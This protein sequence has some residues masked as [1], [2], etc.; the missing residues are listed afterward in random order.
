MGTIGV[1]ID[2]CTLLP[3]Q[4]YQPRLVDGEVEMGIGTHNEPGSRRMRPCPDLP[5]LI[6]DMLDH[7]LGEDPERSYINSPPPKLLAITGE[8]VSQL[9]EDYGFNPARIYS[10]T[11]LSALN[12]PGFSITLLSPPKKDPRSSQIVEWLDTPTDAAGW[13]CLLAPEA[14]TSSLSTSVATSLPSNKNERIQDIQNVPCDAALFGHIL[15]SVHVS[16]VIAEPKITQN[17]T[18]LG[19]GDCGTTL[20]NGSQGL[21]TALRERDINT[22]SLSHGMLAIAN[23]IS[24]R[25]GGTSRALCAVFFTAFASESAN[26]NNPTKGIDLRSI[27][28]ALHKA[29]QSLQQ[30]TAAR[31]GDRTMMDALIPF[32]KTFSD[33]A[34]KGNTPLESIEEAFLVAKRG[35]EATRNIQSKFGWST[36]VS[37]EGGTEAAGRLIPDPG[38]TGIVAIVS[39]I[40]EAMKKQS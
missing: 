4:L 30:V 3:G 38:A 24:E 25:M 5:S 37:A 14:W 23:L 35:G 39:G 21:V 18:V 28:V 34:N 9:K 15:E 6:K 31:E 29:L 11:F 32:V 10:G 26:M 22:S 16:L 20:L 12:A 17:D 8:I 19:D 1:G 33:M 7:I 27:A 13:P 36:Y 40:R 2:G